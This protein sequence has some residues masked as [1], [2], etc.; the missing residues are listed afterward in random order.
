[1]QIFASLCVLNCIDVRNYTEYLIE[2]IENVETT[3]ILLLK[4]NWIFSVYNLVL[5]QKT[6]SVHARAT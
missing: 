2:V 5:C 3:F 1:M 4:Q 6:K